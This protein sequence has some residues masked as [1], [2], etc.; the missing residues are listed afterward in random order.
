MNT[1][2]WKEDIEYDVEYI[3]RQE[4][5]EDR[6]KREKALVGKYIVIVTGKQQDVDLFLQDDKYGNGYW[7]RFLSNAKGFYDES[8]AVIKAKNLQFN[9]PRVAFVQANGKL[10]EVYRNGRCTR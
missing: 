8:A 1:I 9:N 6:K 10:K 5:I 2:D 3:R 4:I 7:T